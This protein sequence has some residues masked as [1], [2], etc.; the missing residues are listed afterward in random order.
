MTQRDLTVTDPVLAASNGGL[1]K[2]KRR[3]AP[4]RFELTATRIIYYQRS[5]FWMAFGALG[6]LLSRLT[7]GKRALELDLTQI[8]AI[9]RGKYGFNKNILDVTMRDGVAHRI[10]IERYDDFTTRLR[11]EL[12]RHASLIEDGEQRWKVSA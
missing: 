4:G 8:A 10:T 9:A 7:A 3:M 5:S 11:A 6:M 2:S 1:F 12:A